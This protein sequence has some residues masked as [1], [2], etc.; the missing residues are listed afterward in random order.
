MHTNPILICFC[1]IL[2]YRD[3]AEHVKNHNKEKKYLI[4][5]TKHNDGNESDKKKYYFMKK[6][7]NKMARQ[8]ELNEAEDM[9]RT[10]ETPISKK[11]VYNKTIVNKWHL[12]IRLNLNKEL[13]QFRKNNIRKKTENESE[14]MIKKLKTKVSSKLHKS[15]KNKQ[16]E[17]NLDPNNLNNNIETSNV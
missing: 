3:L 17:N 11:K 12:L 1:S 15:A 2:Y 16:N 9:N 14:S 5:I 13:I 7:G 4:A 6:F 10:N 8:Q